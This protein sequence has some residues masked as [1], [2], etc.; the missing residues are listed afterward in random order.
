M[1]CS[2]PS[3]FSIRIAWLAVVFFCCCLLSTVGILSVR[4]FLS[5]VYSSQ[6]VWKCSVVFSFMQ[7]MHIG[8]RNCSHQLPRLYFH[9]NR[10][11]GIFRLFL[12]CDCVLGSFRI[13]VTMSD[14]DTVFF[15]TE[16][17][18]FQLSQLSLHYCESS[19][20]TARWE[21]NVFDAF[22]IDNFVF[23]KATVLHAFSSFYDFSIFERRSG[24]HVV[25]L[26]WKLQN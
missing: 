24:T 26:F 22:W 1:S 12:I 5:S 11:V 23:Y 9:I 18:S 19:G 3:W 20:R 4:S 7:S 14:F 16:S 15:L 13:R 6:S 2:C 8:R 17:S 21:R 10:L 25:Y